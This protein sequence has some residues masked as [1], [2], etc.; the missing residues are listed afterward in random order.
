M[1]E[2]LTWKKL[3]RLSMISIYR[4]KCAK[5]CKKVHNY[6]KYSLFSLLQIQHLLLFPWEEGASAPSSLSSPS[7]HL[8]LPR[9]S[10]PASFEANL[11]VSA[12]T[13]SASLEVL[14]AFSEAL[15]S[16]FPA[17]SSFSSTSNSGSALHRPR[18][19]TLTISED[20]WF[21]FFKIRSIFFRKS[22]PETSPSTVFRDPS[23]SRRSSQLVHPATTSRR[24]ALTRARVRSTRRRVSLMCRSVDRFLPRVTGSSNPLQC[25]RPF[26]RV[27][28]GFRHPVTARVVHAPVT[29]SFPS[30]PV[31]FLRLFQAI[32]RLLHRCCC[33]LPFLVAYLLSF[34]VLFCSLCLYFLVSS[35]NYP[36]FCTEFFFYLPTSDGWFWLFLSTTDGRDG[37][38]LGF[39]PFTERHLVRLF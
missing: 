6:S 12:E 17:I 19:R 22:K 21:D 39:V 30:G 35:L 2:R 37:Y 7:R 28:A 38:P 33:C 36:F 31:A 10:L 34:L 8:L 13:L 18:L 5:R 1:P 23:A 27:G 9:P 4:G 24:V 25:R 20:F 32:L 16:S 29:G 15:C 11:L 3:Q 26:L 14:S